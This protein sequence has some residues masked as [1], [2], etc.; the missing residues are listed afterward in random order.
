MNKNRLLKAMNDIAHRGRHG[1]KGASAVEFALILP[2]LLFLIYGLIVYGYL[3]VLQQSLTF[4]A[5]EGAQVAVA[6]DPYNVAAAQYNATVTK[7]SQ[8][9]VA[10]VLD[11]L[12]PDQYAAIVGDASGSKVQVFPPAAPGTDFVRVR[13]VFDLSGSAFFP[14]LSIPFPGIGTLQIPPLPSRITGE[15]SASL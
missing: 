3:M 14:T 12:P 4:A 6:V 8:A 5:Q 11:W 10:R 15:S 2:L 1:Q 9:A 7:T 13:L